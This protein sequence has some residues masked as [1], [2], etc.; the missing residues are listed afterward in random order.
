MVVVEPAVQEDRM[1]STSASVASALP[2]LVLLARYSVGQVVTLPL[3]E[4]RDKAK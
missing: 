2:R 3:C 4:I 1:E